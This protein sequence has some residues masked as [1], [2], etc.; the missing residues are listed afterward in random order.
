MFAPASALICVLLHDGEFGVWDLD[1]Q[2]L[3]AHTYSLLADATALWPQRCGSIAYT[4]SGGNAP[5]C[6]TAADRSVC[7]GDKAHA[8]HGMAPALDVRWLQPGR[9]LVI[10]TAE[11]LV[12]ALHAHG[13]RRRCTR[14]LAYV[15][16][17]FCAT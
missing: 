16:A 9:R 10:L 5:L 13:A 4:V 17:A 7:S 11:R 14:E 12:R 6:H 1:A 2:T 15:C 3:V 8:R